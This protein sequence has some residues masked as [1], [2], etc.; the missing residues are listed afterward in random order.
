MKKVNN[1]ILLCALSLNMTAQLDKDCTKHLTELKKELLLAV[2]CSDG[3]KGCTKEYTYLDNQRLTAA[4]NRFQ[5]TL[6][7]VECQEALRKMNTRSLE[8]F[9]AC[10]ADALITN[11][12]GKQVGWKN[13]QFINEISGAVVNYDS[14]NEWY[15][16]PLYDAYYYEITGKGTGVADLYFLTSETNHP[17]NYFS[18]IPLTNGIKYYG[19]LEAGGSTSKI[20]GEGTSLNPN[21]RIFNNTDPV[22]GKISS[23]GKEINANNNTTTTTKTS[24]N[25]NTNTSKLFTE[26]NQPPSASF[27]MIPPTPTTEDIVVAVS[28][29]IDPEGDPITFEWFLNERFIGRNSQV[30]V[31]DL[32]PGKQVLKL[33][34]KDNK[35]ASSYYEQS[36]NVGSHSSNNYSS[37]YTKSNSFWESSTW[38][39]MVYYAPYI[40]MG[41]FILLML[42]FLSKKNKSQG[43]QE[44]VEKS[45][46]NEPTAPSSIQDA[47]SSESNDEWVTV[48]FCPNC[49]S[50][51]VSEHLFCG[52]CGHKLRK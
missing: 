30:E 28:N 35:G 13:G 43:I 38:M 12:S 14:E 1:L 33:V 21:S 5:A 9:L 29:S 50:K 24:E 4:H 19:T 17:S 44:N 52:K 20:V 37:T 15:K 46:T 22:Y 23:I 26:N 25:N 49:G 42:G 34:V 45:I 41:G 8:V 2:M 11:S 7:T 18:N 16:L 27:S 32:N 36:F 3:H 51:V 10:P 31:E 48:N 39:T 47:P 40:L 6:G